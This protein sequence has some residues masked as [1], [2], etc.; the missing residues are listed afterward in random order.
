[1]MFSNMSKKLMLWEKIYRH[2]WVFSLFSELSNMIPS[3]SPMLIMRRDS[4]YYSVG[5]YFLIWDVR[6]LACENLFVQYGQEK[7]CS[8]VW[9]RMWFLKLYPVANFLLQYGHLKSPGPYWICNQW[10]NLSSK[11]RKNIYRG[12]GR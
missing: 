5:W 11:V 9:T 1:M 10:R 12:F 6:L 4:I 3:F 2:L 8:P 7:G